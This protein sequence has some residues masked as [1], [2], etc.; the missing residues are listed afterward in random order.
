MATLQTRDFSADSGI[1]VNRGRQS[2]EAAAVVKAIKVNCED[3]LRLIE[4][5]FILGLLRRIK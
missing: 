1:I 2:Y 4:D 5:H 3:R